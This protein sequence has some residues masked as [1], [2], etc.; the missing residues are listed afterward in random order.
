MAGN[1]SALSKEQISLI[2]GRLLIEREKIINKEKE[3]GQD[4]YCLD[5]NELA[6]VLDEANIN[7]QTSQEVR[8]RNREFFYFKKLDQALDRIKRGVFGHCEE[9]EGTISFERL[10]ARP[11]ADLCIKCKEL[12]ESSEKNNFF[13]AKS[14]SL[15]KTLL[16]INDPS[17]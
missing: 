15:G 7:I 12:A 17:M 8:F 13:Q 1:N 4:E 2:K 10:L 3:K 16:E 14:K 6:D 11:T 5:K 9:C